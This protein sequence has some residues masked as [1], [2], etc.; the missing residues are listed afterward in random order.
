[1]SRWWRR[2]GVRARLVLSAAV[3]L[4][5]ALAAV[6]VAVAV[7]FTA[8][9][10][11][12]LDRQ[13][14]AEADVLV[15]LTSTDRLPATLPVPAGSPLLAQVVAGDGTVLAA[16]PSASRLQPL[17]TRE[18]AGV[19]TDE[20]GSYAGTPLRLRV[21][22]AVLDGRDVSVVVAAPLASLRRGLRA[23]QLVLLLAV[24]VLVGLVTALT[25]RVAG[26]ALRPVEQL[27]AAAAQLVSSPT[28]P[29]AELPAVSGQDEVARLAHTL[30]ALLASVRALVAQQR[31]FVAD[32]AHELRSPLASLSVQLDVARA[33][34]ATVSV[35]ELVGELAPEV[36]RLQRL[37]G[38]LL[39]LARLEAADPARRQ[40]LDLR[41]VADAAGEPAPV[42][43]DPAALARL[44]A[45][46]RDNATRHG[47]RVVLTTSVIERSAVLDVDDDGPG[48]PP[49]DRLRVLDRWVRLDDARPRPEGGS[50][51]GLAIVAETARAHGGSVEVLDSPLGGTRVRVRLPYHLRPIT[52][53]GHRDVGRQGAGGVGV[54]DCPDAFGGEE[55]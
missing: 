26:L 42:L 25:W 16:T 14:R 29:M 5:I 23:L 48:I 24:P 39:T 32:A 54:G 4:A 15:A 27:R 3:P 20:A 50:G 22:P 45:N 49:A 2:R 18:R 35:E 38:D 34:P 47:G 52:A 44:V 17:S 33:H 12:D 43:A 13:T 7:V 1:M 40:P 8:G 6:A 30:Q 53:S 46:L 55:G 31:S 37:V 36:E 21:Q 11:R 9:L 19:A 10:V 41:Q 51:L 28:R